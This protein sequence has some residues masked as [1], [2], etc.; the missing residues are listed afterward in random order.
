MFDSFCFT[1]IFFFLCLDI[2]LKFTC[3]VVQCNTLIKQ[4]FEMNNKACKILFEIQKQNNKQ[5]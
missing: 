3:T 1:V 5:K 4:E 2:F